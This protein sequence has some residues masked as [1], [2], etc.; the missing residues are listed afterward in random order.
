M[1][2][3]R[4]GAVLDSRLLALWN[5]SRHRQRSTPR[6]VIS[7]NQLGSEISRIVGVVP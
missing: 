3:G 4:Q 2:F 6:G 1:P 5:A 7:K